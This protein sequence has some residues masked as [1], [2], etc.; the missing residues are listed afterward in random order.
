[1]AI[2]VRLKEK[3]G[4]FVVEAKSHLLMTFGAKAIFIVV[5]HGTDALPFY[6]QWKYGWVEGS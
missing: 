1:V 5:G 6:I 2:L 4:Q 3:V